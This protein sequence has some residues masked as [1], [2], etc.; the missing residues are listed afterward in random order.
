[1]AR[2]TRLHKRVIARFG[3]NEHGEPIDRALEG[4]L[5][6]LLKESPFKLKAFVVFGSR[7]R[8]D[9]KP[10]SDT[11]VLLI[12]DG[13]EGKTLQEVMRELKGV[14]N[15][16]ANLP[17]AGIEARI[18]TPEEATKLLH[19]RTSLTILDALEGGV[20]LY[21]DG[22]WSKLKAEFED[23]KKKGLVKKTPGGWE[24][25]T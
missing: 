24:I 22:F 7:A 1:M 21:D 9:W 20:T 17:A 18:F 14:W 4:F 11:D 19:K 16:L 13:L 10:W 2:E 6:L 15:G 12:M 25:K 23:M 3:L 8:G 5:D